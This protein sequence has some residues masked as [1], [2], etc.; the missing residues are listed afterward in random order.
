MSELKIGDK[1]VMN[2]KYPVAEENKGIVF[3]VISKPFNICGVMLVTLKDRGGGYAV[4]GLS[5]VIDKE[6]DKR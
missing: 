4:D 2:G 1:V 3:T 5:K 6:N